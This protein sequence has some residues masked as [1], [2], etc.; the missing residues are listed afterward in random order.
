[1]N[2]RTVLGLAGTSAL[3]GLAG[4]IDAVREHF[5]LQGVIPV[6]ITNEGEETRNLLIEARESESGRRS[7]E[8]SY[9][10]TPGENVTAPHLSET[11]L[12]LRVAVVEDETEAT[13]RAASVTPDVDL[14]AIRLN[15]DDLVVELQ[16]DGGEDEIVDGDDGPTAPDEPAGDAD[17]NET[18]T[19]DAG[20]A[21]DGNE[22]DA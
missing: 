14:V 9:T 20:D 19:G 4:C 21:T 3:A 10:V 17:D 5:G 8:E 11:E 16:R 6:E 1:M 18:Q 12:N 22:S 2:R 13:V 15:D 7:Y